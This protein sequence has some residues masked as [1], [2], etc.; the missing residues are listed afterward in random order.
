[1]NADEDYCLYSPFVV[2]G[3]PLWSLVP[4]PS[5]SRLVPSV[6]NLCNLRN[7]RIV[8]GA[9]GVLAVIQ[10]LMFASVTVSKLLFSLDFELIVNC[11]G[12]NAP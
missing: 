2:F 6:L 11:R 12:L 9:L 3:F 1:M 10:K 5:L 4:N 8:L 7:L